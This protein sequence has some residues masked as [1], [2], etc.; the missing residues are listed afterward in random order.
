MAAQMSSNMSST[1]AFSFFDQ[2]SM[3]LDQSTPPASPSLTV[4]TSAVMPQNLV[5][6]AQG[7][8]YHAQPMYPYHGM[9]YH[10]Q[11][12]LTTLTYHPQ[13]AYP[14]AHHLPSVPQN[15]A[16]Y[17]L[18]TLVYTHSHQLPSAIG[19][20]SPNGPATNSVLAVSKW[21]R[22]TSTGGHASKHQKKNAVLVMEMVDPS[23]IC[24]VGPP[25]LAIPNEAGTEDQVADGE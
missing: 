3:F 15:P 10:P 9:V 5:P 14:Y 21:K 25:S 2:E 19:V 17:Y 7:G 18:E 1:Q 6:L 8:A 13:T 24:G 20:L 4:S 22:A 23:P 11:V 16:P 12:P